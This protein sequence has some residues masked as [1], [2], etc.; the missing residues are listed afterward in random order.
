LAKVAGLGAEDFLND[1]RVAQ[2]YNNVGDAAAYLA[3]LRR[4]AGDKDGR[5]V[6]KPLP[7]ELLIIVGATARWDLN[8]SM[9]QY[10]HRKVL[11]SD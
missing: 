7:T 6:H 10:R 8:D 2:S 11:P 3:K 1:G 5:L 9:H 4:D